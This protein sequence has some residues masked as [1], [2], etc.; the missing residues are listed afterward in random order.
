MRLRIIIAFLLVIAV[1]TKCVGQDT[2][3]LATCEWDPYIGSTTPDNGYVAEVVTEALKRVNYS[4]Q[5]TF[6]PWARAVSQAGCGDFD[7][8]F[9]E[10]LNESRTSKFVY[11]DPFPGGPVGLYKRKD[12]NAVYSISPQQDPTKA[13]RSLQDY[14][15]GVV[16]GYINTAEFDQASFLRKEPSNN[17]TNNLRM[18]YNR[19]VD[20]IFVDK[21][22]AEYIISSKFPHYQAELEFMPPAFET[23][24]LHIA[25]SKQA[26][27]FKGKIN[28]FNSGLE[29]I[30]KDGTLAKIIIKYG[31][32]NTL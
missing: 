13:L 27:D 31:V 3:K 15:F 29:Q 12:N 24:S 26:A 10:Y 25:F 21:L 8:V 14:K 11:S 7:G 19:R 5:I 28:A 2:V 1:A 18:L 30:T 17:D 9:P 32:E 16:R 6:L 4:T 22:T 23:K 20:F